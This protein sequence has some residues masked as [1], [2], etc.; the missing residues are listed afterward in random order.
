MIGGLVWGPPMMAVLLGAGLWCSIKLGFFQ[1]RHPVLWLKRTIGGRGE[2]AGP[3]ELRPFETM[4]TALAATVGTGNLVGVAAAIALGGPGAV[5]W[6]WVAAIL[7]MMTGF[8]ENVLGI[9]YR[10]RDPDGTVHGGPMYYMERG[11]GLRWLGLLFSLL[12]AAASLGIGGSIQSH[13]MAAGL[14]ESFGIP[15]LLTG[16]VVAA[17]AAIVVLGGAARVGAVT[18]KL[19]PFMV[20]GY[21]L[22]GG[23][24]LI[25]RADRI[26]AALAEIVSGALTPQAAGAGGGYGIL[27]AMRMG[28]SR[29][30]FSNEAGLGSSV[31]IH[32]AG[33]V[34]EPV[35]QGMWSIFE[36]FADTLVVCTMTALVI[37]TSGVYDSAAYLADYDQIGHAGG[38]LSGVRLTAA[39]FTAVFG[40]AGGVFLTLALVLFAFSTVLGWGWYGRQAWRYLTGARAERA[41]S[42]VQLAALVAGAISSQELVWSLSDACNGLMAATN[43][44]AVVMLTGRVQRE[45]RRYLAAQAPETFGKRKE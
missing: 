22:A 32:A 38:P 28:L 23:V 2:S 15:P 43:L 31:L 40:P 10:V 26:S 44:I 30:I 12:C 5:F 9:C 20:A 42:V 37:L 17:L 1:L 33:R 14:Q 21:L 18:G 36:V 29:G 35:Q 39:A 4:T 19:V 8:S 13:A 25:C 6:M 7:G 27:L 45:L 34:R 24:C 11:L 3:G 41:F 16:L